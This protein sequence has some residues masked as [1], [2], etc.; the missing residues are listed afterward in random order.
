[1]C[2]TK[3]FKEQTAFNDPLQMYQMDE[4]LRVNLFDE[5]SKID[6]GGIKFIANANGREY[7][8]KRIFGKP[9]GSQGY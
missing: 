3:H 2:K 6:C 1:M 4:I 8:E 9:K 7:L 5:L